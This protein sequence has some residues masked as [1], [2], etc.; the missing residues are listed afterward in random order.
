MFTTRHPIRTSHFCFPAPVLTA[1]TLCF[2]ALSPASA[3][4]ILYDNSSAY[5]GAGMNACHSTNGLCEAESFTTANGVTSIT[6]LML[7]LDHVSTSGVVDLAY[8]YSDNSGEPGS[9]LGVFANAATDSAL[10]SF[11]AMY[12]FGA[13]SAAVVPNTK[14][15]IALSQTNCGGCSGNEISWGYTNQMTGTGVSGQADAA[16][17][18]STW[19]PIYPQSLEVMTVQGGASSAPEPASALM[20]AGGAL[21]LVGVHR[22]EGRRPLGPSR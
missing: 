12:D 13:T 19:S 8:L 4:T 7:S 21:L 9:M 18:S 15:W 5:V 22:L 17:V 20:L 14:Y 6:D 1:L 16:Y 3:D 11:L 2:L 10:P